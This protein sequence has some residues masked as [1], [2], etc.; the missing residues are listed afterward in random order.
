MNRRIADGLHNNSK[1]TT[2]EK[3][4]PQEKEGK[5][6]IYSD[7]SNAELFRDMFKERICWSKDYGGWFIFNGKVWKRDS[8]NAIKQYAILLYE[9]LQRRLQGFDGDSTAL[10]LFARHVKQS[11][12]DGKLNAMLN[13]AQALMGVGVDKFDSRNDLFNCNN[14]TI[15]FETGMFTR[16]RP[17]DYQTKISGADYIPEAVCPLWRKFLDDIFLQDKEVISFMQRVVGYSMTCSINEHCMFIFYGGGRNGKT[18]FIEVISKIFG[19]YSLSV[20]A[21]SFNKK[22]NAGIPN[23]IAR[24]KGARMVTAAEGSENVTLDESLIK[25]IT[26]GDRITAR[27]LNKEFFDFYPTF[28]IFLYTNKKPNIRGMDT[29]IW[30]RIRMIPFDLNLTAEQED[31]ELPLKLAEEM[32]GILSWAV[33]GYKQWKLQGLNTPEIISKATLHYQSEEDDIGQFIED[34]CI[35]EPTS[36][37]PIHDFKNKFY[38]INKYGKSQKS[39]SEYM[40]RHGYLKT[41]NRVTLPNGD[42]SRAYTG[43]RLKDNNT[44]ERYD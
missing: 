13:C 35:L 39:I 4:I 2:A 27:F 10:D 28:K 17:E 24:L 21:S 18:T 25:Q 12:N 9:E 43:L 11:G 3:N 1:Q 22:P 42:R 32:P 5:S 37:V 34:W 16:F 44:T 31:K 30:R 7:V 40:R 20:P 29:G 8:N 41:D 36:H 6:T 15:N 19:D 23:D 26:G 14:G 38:Q 33:E